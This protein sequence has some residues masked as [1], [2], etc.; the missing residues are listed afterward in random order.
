M[1]WAGLIKLKEIL[2]FKKIQPK[3]IKMKPII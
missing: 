1:E 3:I 2:K